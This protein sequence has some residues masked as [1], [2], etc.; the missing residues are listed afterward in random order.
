MWHGLLLLLGHWLL[1]PGCI[2]R[3]WAGRPG[4]RLGRCPWMAYIAQGMGAHAAGLP[5]E[6][7]QAAGGVCASGIGS[8][9]TQC[10]VEAGS[11][12]PTECWSRKLQWLLGRLKRCGGTSVSSTS[13]RACSAFRFLA[14]WLRCWHVL[15]DGAHTS[16]QPL[17]CSV[18]C[19]T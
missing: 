14:V 13:E 2:L 7:P 9:Q 1:F 17:T 4:R 6:Q 18:V 19:S 8:P 10:W 5:T 15:S 12:P 16:P 3:W 11:G